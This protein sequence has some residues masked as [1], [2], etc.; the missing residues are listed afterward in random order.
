MEQL[1]A[2]L[3]DLNTRY[4]VVCSEIY[5]VEEKKAMCIKA[6]R[7]ILQLSEQGNTDCIKELAQNTLKFVL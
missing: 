4:S 3:S 5:D 7:R 6:L 1:Y 2:Q